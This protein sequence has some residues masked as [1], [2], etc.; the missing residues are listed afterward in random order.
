MWCTLKESSY[1]DSIIQV[2]RLSFPCGCSRDGCQNPNGRI[3]FNPARVR[4]HYLHIFRRLHSDS[5]CQSGNSVSDAEGEDELEDA[6]GDADEL[7]DSS[8][9][10]S[11]TLGS[12]SKCQAEKQK[13]PDTKQHAHAAPVNLMNGP[14]TVVNQSDASATAQIPLR[15]PAGASILQMVRSALG[16]S[17]QGASGVTDVVDDSVDSAASQSASD[18]DADSGDERGSLSETPSVVEEAEENEEDEQTDEGAAE[19]DSE[20]GDAEDESDADEEGA[21]DSDSEL[22]MPAAASAAPHAAVPAIHITGSTA[23]HSLLALNDCYKPP[24][25]NAVLS[26]NSAMGL[27]V[28]PRGLE[29]SPHIYNRIHTPN[30]YNV[31]FGNAHPHAHAHPHHP[32]GTCYPLQGGGVTLTESQPVSTFSASSAAASYPLLHTHAVPTE[33]SSPSALHDLVP[34]TESLQTATAGDA[35]TDCTVSNP[36][37]MKAS[38][39]A[40]LLLGESPPIAVTAL[41]NVSIT[42]AS[43]S[44]AA[45]SA[46]ASPMSPMSGLRQTSDLVAASI[47]L[48]LGGFEHEHES[49]S[50]AAPSVGSETDSTRTYTNLK[51]PAAASA[52][53]ELFSAPSATEHNSSV[54]NGPVGEMGTRTTSSAPSPDYVPTSGITSLD[55][56]VSC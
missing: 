37:A 15:R 12:C 45:I 31:L 50:P 29:H 21:S 44:S 11:T 38:S 40:H 51:S 22:A 52:S 54:L 28:K 8:D 32:V 26:A 18:A 5:L 13:V 56:H 46:P 1:C 23:P 42:T 43:S 53:W 4:S 20:E 33:G 30:E 14:L 10:P 24:S 47:M 35:C 16:S 48:P 7:E 36:N 6:D 9:F 39:L 17:S 49:E 2:D 41:Q 25:A 19:K 34:T 27:F 55:S 3:E